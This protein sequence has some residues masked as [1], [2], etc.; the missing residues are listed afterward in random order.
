MAKKRIKPLLLD[1]EKSLWDKFKMKV[2]KDITLNEAVV[3][4]IEREVKR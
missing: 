4:L 2:T 3:K 1:I